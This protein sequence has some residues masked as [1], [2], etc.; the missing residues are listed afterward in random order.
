MHKV[1]PLY[2]RTQNKT[3]S[4]LGPYQSNAGEPVR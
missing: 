2:A 3:V 1:L 4:E